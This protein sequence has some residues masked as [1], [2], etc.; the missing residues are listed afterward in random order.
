MIRP[1]EKR[2]IPGL[3]SLLRQVAQVHHD[4][5]PDLFKSPATKFSAEDLEAMLDEGRL[6]IFV[7]TDEADERVLG[8]CFCEIL[9]KEGNRVLTDIRT[10]YIHDLVV[11]E[12]VRGQGLGGRLYDH[13]VAYAR[14]QGCY[15]L[16]LNVWTCNP[17]AMRFYEKCGMKPQ[18]I[19][20]ETIL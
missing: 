18:K 13:A 11:D 20:M 6:P 7:L 17:A 19:G 4:G 15:N 3:L 10:L 9:R 8:H 2:D 16:T 14:E 12:S 1:A 5:R